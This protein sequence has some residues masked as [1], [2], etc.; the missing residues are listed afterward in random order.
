MEMADS[1]EGAGAEDPGEVFCKIPMRV[2]TNSK[3]VHGAACI[4]YP[5]VLDEVAQETGGSFFIL[6][7]SVHEV[8]ILPDAGNGDG[9]RL[10]E[11]I[12]M[13]NTT[14]VAPEEVLSD[15]L[16]RYDTAEKMVVMV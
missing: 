9:E 4:L 3:R 15:T 16:Y 1:G 13:V 5:G 14:Q 10:K 12:R 11:I 8:I 2:L 7:S 6:P